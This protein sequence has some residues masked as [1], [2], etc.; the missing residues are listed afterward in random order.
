MII[1]IVMI[2]VLVCLEIKGS[3]EL[4][5]FYFFFGAAAALA[6]STCA[7]RT[8]GINSEYSKNLNKKYRFN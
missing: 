2:T 1:V 6:S 5:L 3:I 7:G 8:N 4:M